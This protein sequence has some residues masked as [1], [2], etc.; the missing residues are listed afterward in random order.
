VTTTRKSLLQRVRDTADTA[1]WEEFFALY[2]PLLE[3]YARAHGLSR[4][5]AEEI[6]DQCLAALV[7]RMPG[8]R[9]ERERGTFKGWLHRIARGKLADRARRRRPA[10]PSTETLSTVPDAG[11]APDEHW[12]RV[13]RAE[14]LRHALREAMRGES[15]TTRR[16]LALVLNEDLSVEEIRARTGLDANR[17]YKARAR[18]LRRLREVL[19]RLGED[20]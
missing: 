4:D 16:V 7:E 20:A 13:W 3:G 2:A 11:E 6:R 10:Q 19:A 9:Y 1:A 5:D 12:E 18:V 17:V 15:E 14:H 8:F